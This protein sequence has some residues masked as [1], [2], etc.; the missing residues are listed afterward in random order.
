[1]RNCVKLK[2][3][4]KWY[5]KDVRITPADRGG[6]KRAKFLKDNGIVAVPF[7]NGTGFFVMKRQSYQKKNWWLFS[8]APKFKKLLVPGI[9]LL[10]RLRKT[11]TVC[12]LI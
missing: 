2:S 7:D 8:I 4:A 12:C 5:A 3:S 9:A 6:V 11:S 10:F 1:M